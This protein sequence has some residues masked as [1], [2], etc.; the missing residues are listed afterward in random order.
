[1]IIRRRDVFHESGH[2]SGDSACK[3]QNGML[4]LLVLAELARVWHGRGAE[5]QFGRLF[6]DVEITTRARVMARRSFL[7]SLSRNP[8]K[9]L[10]SRK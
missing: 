8:L 4:P 9:S 10:D 2:Y 6:E 5:G 1:M 7:T 3:N